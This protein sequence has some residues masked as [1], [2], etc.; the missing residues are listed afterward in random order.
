MLFFILFISFVSNAQQFKIKWSQILKEKKENQIGSILKIDSNNIYITK[1]DFKVG[2]AIYGSY[3]DSWNRP[4]LNAY[5]KLDLDFLNESQPTYPDKL[6][7]GLI[8]LGM[9]KYNNCFFKYY[10]KYVSKNNSTTVKYYLSK[11]DLN[12]SNSSLENYLNLENND[13]KNPS[14]YIIVSNDKS[15]II[16]IMLQNYGTNEKKGIKELFIACNNDKGEKLWEK[17]IEINY[18][19]DNQL[20]IFKGNICVQNNG[21]IFIYAYETRLDNKIEKNFSLYKIANNGNS[22]T[23]AKYDMGRIYPYGAQINISPYDNSVNVMGLY[24]YISEN[25][26][27]KYLQKTNTEGMMAYKFDSNGNLINKSLKSYSA[28]ILEKC[29]ANGTIFDDGTIYPFDIIDIFYRTDSGAYIIAEYNSSYTSSNLSLSLNLLVANV[30][31]NGDITNIIYIPKKQRSSTISQYYIGS[32]CF[33]RDNNLHILFSE[34]N[35]NENSE[36]NKLKWL[37]IKDSRCVMYTI[38]KNSNV[39]KKTLFKNDDLIFYPSRC[40]D[41]DGKIFLHKRNKSYEAQI[42]ILDINN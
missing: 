37:D 34:N 14:I 27:K 2:K 21:D 19:T 41:I 17:N 4:S 30:S 39:S 33:I 1:Y 6:E 12:F 22:V 35:P 20:N 8:Y 18:N 40:F 26:G 38:N 10:V 15:K 9:V 23:Y 16:T 42:G 32:F 13:L 7:E 29:E 28:S 25:E 24:N 11:M 3:N 36:S 31:P 5:Y